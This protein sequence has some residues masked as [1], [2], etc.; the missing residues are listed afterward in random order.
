[1]LR[2]DHKAK[3]EVSE[4]SSNDDRPR[5]AQRM[6]LVSVSSCSCHCD[7]R[8]GLSLGMRVSA[9]SVFSSC[10][11]SF[12]R[13]VTNENNTQTSKIG[14]K[15]R[16]AALKSAPVAR[17]VP[18]TSKPET[19]RITR[20]SSRAATQQSQ[21][22][23]LIESDGATQHKRYKN[24]KS[25]YRKRPRRVDTRDTSAEPEVS[26]L[27]KSVR[28]SVD[29]TVGLLGANDNRLCSDFVDTTDYNM[30]RQPFDASKYTHGISEFD[31]PNEHKLLEVTGYATDIYQRLFHAEVRTV[32]H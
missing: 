7:Q 24:R 30:L 11:V 6:P 19:V 22:D 4:L 12:Q 16:T 3:G 27:R 23:P 18:P 25:V 15:L 28:R 13:D 14:R 17:Q 1:M 29:G 2:N 8:M 31:K 5:R 20:S 32:P 10:C 9:S 21:I 26:R